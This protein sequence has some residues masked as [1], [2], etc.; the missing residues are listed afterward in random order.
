RRTD[1]IGRLGGEEFAVILPGDSLDEVAI[2]AEKLRRA[3]EDLSPLEGG[4]GGEEATVT[5]S[6]GGASLSADVVGAQ[7]LMR[8]A[9]QALYEAK[10]QGRNR[11]HMWTDPG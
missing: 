11:V 8:Y 5:L 1:M 6:V 10:R 9:D 4:T 2:V 3:I 7:L